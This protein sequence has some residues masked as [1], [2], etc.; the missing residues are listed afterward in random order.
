MKQVSFSELN[1]PL[2]QNL[3]IDSELVAAIL[4]KY[5]GFQEYIESAESQ[6]EAAFI[7]K[8]RLIDFIW[9]FKESIFDTELKVGKNSLVY[10][11][12]LYL[13]QATG[14]IY[15]YRCLITQDVAESV[16]REITE[17]MNSAKRFMESIEA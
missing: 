2:I 17:A 13:D 10:G 12:F 16:N 1:P 15:K 8:Y 6:A 3:G 5:Q 11:T 4:E 9:E 7:E 14:R